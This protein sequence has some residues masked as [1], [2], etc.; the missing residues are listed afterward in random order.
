MKRFT[1]LLLLTASAASAEEVYLGLYRQWNQGTTIFEIGSRYPDITGVASGSRIT[2]PRN[3]PTT[4]A[5]MLLFAGEFASEVNV[6]YTGP[7]VRSGTGRDEDFIL[8]LTSRQEGAKFQP[9]RGKFRDN[10]YVFSGGRNFADSQAK[11]NLREYGS[12]LALR[13]TPG[14]K[15]AAVAEETIVFAGLEYA[16]TYSKYNFY[17]AVQYNS[18]SL[19]GPGMPFSMTPIGSGLSFTNVIHEAAIGGGVRLPVFES[20]CLDLFAGP[21][22]GW[23]E[24]RDFHRLRGITFYMS[25]AGSGFLYRM[26][27]V[28]RF[29]RV[30]LR[31]SL[32]GHRRFSR[33]TIYARGLDP[34]Y[35]LLPPQRMYLHTKE[36]S[37][38]GSF[39]YQL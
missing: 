10:Q 13:F 39:D 36:W 30:L 15:A 18:P 9:E 24:S 38:R 28:S 20:L 14:E 8:S 11:V 26:Q 22:L 7:S 12:G 3:F 16:Y 35:N 6:H 37:V 17:D 29:E 1:C 31:A 32:S 5:E 27:L 23:E 33:G 21:V 19:L 25:N 34:V 4:G 2:Y